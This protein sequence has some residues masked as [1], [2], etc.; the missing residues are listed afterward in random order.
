MGD[1]EIR[2]LREQEA[3]S[4]WGRVRVG[5]S[6]KGFPRMFAAIGAEVVQQVLKQGPRIKLHAVF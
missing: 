4:V 2:L 1:L 3:T 5:G 6:G